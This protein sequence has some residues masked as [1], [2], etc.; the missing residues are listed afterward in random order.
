MA[1]IRPIAV[2]DAPAFCKVLDTVCRE[3]K[4]LGA[5]EGP[6]LERVETFV[7]KNVENG[8][9]QFVAEE[10]G[11]VIGW[12]D[13]VPGEPIA[14][15]RHVGTLGM[16]ILKEHR[17]QGIGR[18]LMETTIEAARKLGIE[19]IELTVYA[20]NRNALRLYESLG[21]GV[22]GTKRKGRFVD[23]VYDD[24]VLMALH[25]V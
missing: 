9:P 2:T 17:G 8:W 18:R 21:F 4:Y 3:R 12:C 20:S 7:G 19:K 15:T 13:I 5:I 22:E 1:T 16:G 25:L 24:I 14:G 11:E 6:T 10:D 23:G